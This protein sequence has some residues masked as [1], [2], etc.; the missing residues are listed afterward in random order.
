MKG[1]NKIATQT[2]YVNR[3]GKIS[4]IIHADESDVIRKIHKNK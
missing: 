3:T 4:E 1:M 2:N